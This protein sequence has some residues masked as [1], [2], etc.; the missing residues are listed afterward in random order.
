MSTNS[1]A[2]RRRGRAPSPAAAVLARRGA[3]RAWCE[4][5]GDRDAKPLREESGSDEDAEEPHRG[6]ENWTP[7]SQICKSLQAKKNPLGLQGVSADVHV[8]YGVIKKRVSQ[9]RVQNSHNSSVYCVCTV[10]TPLRGAASRPLS[11]CSFLHFNYTVTPRTPQCPPRMAAA[12]P[13]SSPAIFQRAARLQQSCCR[14][15]A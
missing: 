15:L 13:I 5:Q 9:R 4:P 12:A 3:G 10:Y 7:P 6:V 14:P 8:D 2:Q 11:D 1:S